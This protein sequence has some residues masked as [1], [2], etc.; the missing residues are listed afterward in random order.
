[1]ADFFQ[2]YL[3]VTITNSGQKN[4][5]VERRLPRDITIA[6]LKVMYYLFL[7]RPYF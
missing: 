6:N 3:N 4:A 2:E 1:M 7:P 5:F